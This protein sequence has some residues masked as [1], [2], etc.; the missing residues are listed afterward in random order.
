M[1]AVL[2][3][4]ASKGQLFIS[5]GVLVH[6]ALTL[7]ILS[8]LASLTISAL[9]GRLHWRLAAAGLDLIGLLIAVKASD[10]ATDR[11]H[12]PH[13]RVAWIATSS[14]SFTCLAVVARPEAGFTALATHSLQAATVIL[15]LAMRWNL[16]GF[17][18]LTAANAA[19]SAGIFAIA[20]GFGAGS[21]F[22]VW[23]QM[24]LPGA[25]G[26]A[27]VLI[28]RRAVKRS[29]AHAVSIR[30]DALT[31]DV[32]SGA[33]DAEARL[34]HTERQI[35]DLLEKVARARSLPLDPT[36]AQAAR[37]LA[38]E[39]RSQLLKECSTDWLVEALALTGL[40]SDVAVVHSREG[41]D[42]IP[43]ASRPSV[44]AITMLLATASRPGLGRL[45]PGSRPPRCK[46]VHFVAEFTEEQTVDLIWRGAGY[47]KNELSPALWSEVES[48][49]TPRFRSDPAGISLA[50]TIP[51]APAW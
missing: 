33:S 26:T 37:E 45:R 9:D 28:R 1:T 43:E 21:G 30:L 47:R 29:S 20:P 44:L 48:L 6:I 19:L 27:S 39:L 49:G 51:A 35:R 16:T 34:A 32:V 22:L 50:V 31:A 38:A 17:I 12:L 42:R 13:L 2:P 36:L 8:V 4:P 3:A 46:R 25:I 15:L 11:A 10:R 24:L 5:R 41:V 40:S 7:W 14:L 18:S 23:F